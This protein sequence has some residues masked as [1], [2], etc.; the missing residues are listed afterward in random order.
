MTR[1]NL[2]TLEDF[3]PK[4]ETRARRIHSKTIRDKRKKQQE[5]VNSEETNSATNEKS[6]DSSQNPAVGKSTS[7]SPIDA[8]NTLIANPTRNAPMGDQTIRE[9]AVAPAVQ[10]PLCITFPQGETPFQLRKF[11]TAAKASEIRR[12]ILGIKQKHEESLYEY[13][14]RFK[15]PCASCPQHG[16][17]E[18]TLIQYFYEGLLPMEMKMIKAASGGA[19]FNMKPTQARE[20]IST[21]A[22]K[23]ELKQL[24]EHLKYA[25]LGE[26]E[27]LPVIISNKLS[28]KEE[29]DLVTM[30]RAHK[31]AIGC[32]LADI[33]G[34]SPSTYMH[35]I[36][37]KE[38]WRRLNP[39]MM[40]VMKNE[41]QRLLDDDFIYPISDSKWVSPIHVVPEKT[42]V[43][44]VEN[45]EGELVPIRVQ[46]GWRVCI[47][48]RKLNS[49]TRNDH[50]PVPFI[51]QMIE[52]L[53]GKSHYCCLDGFSSFFPNPSSVGRPR[54]DDV[55]MPLRNFHL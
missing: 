46:N 18:Q 20:L 49:L 3:E 16:L 10:Q 47:D 15:K 23:L 12:S 38:G 31:E 32:T 50:F 26:N 14:E 22:P 11:F 17:R 25:F 21:M 44:I 19:L 35:K 48:Y 55:Y 33:K 52:R 4:I 54:E 13:W 2:G 39:P 42:G 45:S 43:T 7:T 8:N 28:K 27:T 29:D 41:I 1:Q 24:P 40:E 37:I 6:T 34:L 9:L 53:A 30:L 36:N 5:Q 51:D